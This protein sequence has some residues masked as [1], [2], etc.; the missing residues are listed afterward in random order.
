MKYL[1]SRWEWLALPGKHFLPIQSMFSMQSVTN[2]CFTLPRQPTI[3]Q[4]IP[5]WPPP[6]N[7]QLELFRAKTPMNIAMDIDHHWA[8]SAIPI[9]VFSRIL[10]V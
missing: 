1:G 2:A 8:V 10:F 9:S 4:S 3:T 6:V 7:L 5:A